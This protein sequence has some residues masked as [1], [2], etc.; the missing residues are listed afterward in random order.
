MLLFDYFIIILCDWSDICLLFMYILFGWLGTLI[1][2]F[3]LTI[4]IYLIVEVD[5]RL[6]LIFLCYD[7][8][9]LFNYLRWDVSFGVLDIYFTLILIYL[10]IFLFLLSFQFVCR[11]CY[12]NVCKCEH[13]HNYASYKL[14]CWVIKLGFDDRWRKLSSVLHCQYEFGWLGPLRLAS[15]MSLSFISVILIS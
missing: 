1:Y 15:S 6:F 3:Y 9:F 4:Y 14:R 12:L 7:L 11:M 8:L 2:Y 10:F 13:T 5:V